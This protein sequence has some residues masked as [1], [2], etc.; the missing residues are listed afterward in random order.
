M[1]SSTLDLASPRS[2]QL[3]LNFPDME[4]DDELPDRVR[5]R[6]P[7]GGVGFTKESALDLTRRFVLLI[8]DHVIRR[9]HGYLPGPQ[10]IAIRVLVL[11][12]LLDPPQTKW[13]LRSYARELKCSGAWLSRIA[14]EF[15]DEIGMGAHWQRMTARDVYAAAATTAHAAHL[16]GAPEALGNARDTWTQPKR[17][18]R[19]SGPH[20]SHVL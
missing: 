7:P 16:R 12:L 18:R 8:R 11:E 3:L 9:R 13:S 1:F 20:P 19:G 17:G 14:L 5:R 2:R 15:A 6:R 10:T 4:W